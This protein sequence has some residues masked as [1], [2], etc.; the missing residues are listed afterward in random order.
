MKPKM[1]PRWHQTQVKCA[2]GNTFTTCSTKSTLSV[3]ICSACHP[4]YTGKQRAVAR[5]GQVEKFHQRYGKKAEE[6]A[7][8]K[9]K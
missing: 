5:E 8:T 2:C 4:Y 7:T 6:L 1:H 3:E 9:K